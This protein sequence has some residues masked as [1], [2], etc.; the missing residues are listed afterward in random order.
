MLVLLRELVKNLA[1]RMPTGWLELV[2]NYSAMRDLPGLWPA[3]RRAVGK[4]ELYASA[5]A[6]MEPGRPVLFLEF[7]VWKG[8]SIRRWAGLEVHPGS[9]FVGF[10]SFVGLP[11]DWRQRSA[12]HFSTG[13]VLPVLDDARVSFVPGWFH[14]TLHGWLAGRS[15]THEQQVLVH[16][17]SDLHS[18]A[19]Y[20]LTR[21]HDVFPRYFVL[22]DDYG[23][24]EARAVRDYVRAY[25]AT[26]TPMFGRVRKWYAQVPGQVFGVIEREAS[27]HA[28]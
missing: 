12:G 3:D 7:G 6:A 14:E 11:E 8:T 25:G 17:D 10:D 18:S 21:L 9:R 15:W 27:Q 22:F 4:S 28:S 19:L 13:G 24:G 26:F 23:A 20:V 2:T 1:M 5:R 16:I